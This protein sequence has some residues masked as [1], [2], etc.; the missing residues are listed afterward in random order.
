M[1][2]TYIFILALELLPIKINNTKLIEGITYAIRELRSETFADDTS[3]FIKRNPN[4]LRKC[5]EFLE[6]FAR[7][8]LQCNLDK[9]FVILIGGNF[10]IED[11]L[12]PELALT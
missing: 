6:N 9:T 11:K 7:I 4:Y 10:D 5:I 3:I 2:S 8:G 12:C 1:V